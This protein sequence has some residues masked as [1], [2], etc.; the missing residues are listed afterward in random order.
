LRLNN[1]WSP[2]EREAFEALVKRHNTSIGKYVWRE[3]G[4]NKI[5]LKDALE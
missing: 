5:L 2:A 1:Y 4:T 3:K